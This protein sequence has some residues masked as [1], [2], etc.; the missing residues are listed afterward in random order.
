MTLVFDTAKKR[1]AKEPIEFTLDGETF[2]FTPPKT[3]ALALAESNTE[4]LR[5][6]LNWLSA[7][8]S[9]EQSEKL[10]DRLMDFGD[11]LEA[12]DLVKIVGALIEEMAGRPTGPSPG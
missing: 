8:L 11:P 4:Q 9:D 7:G 10:H 2:V 1:V 5:A 12:V 3:A 6:Q